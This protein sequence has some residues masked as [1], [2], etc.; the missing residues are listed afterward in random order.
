MISLGFAD[1]ALALTG[2]KR[3]QMAFFLARVEPKGGV[4][5]TDQIAHIC[6][7]RPESGSHDLGPAIGTHR[8]MR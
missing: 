5:R 3:K 2:E 7:A 4:V 8:A 1:F 6:A